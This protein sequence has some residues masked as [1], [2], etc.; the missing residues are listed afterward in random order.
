VTGRQIILLA[1]DRST[2]ERNVGQDGQDDPPIEPNEAPTHRHKGDGGSVLP[3]LMRRRAW[4][5]DA[6]RAGRGVASNG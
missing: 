6:G 1:V 2:P 5:L 3:A 4:M